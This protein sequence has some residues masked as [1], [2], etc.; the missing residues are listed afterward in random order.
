ALKSGGAFLPIDPE[1]PED[2]IRFILEDSGAKILVTGRDTLEKRK[3]MFDGIK[4]SGVELMCVEDAVKDGKRDDLNAEVPYDALAYVI[5]TSGSTGKPKGVMLTNKNL[6]NFVDDDEKNHEIQG[7]TKRGHVSLAIAA[8][9]FDFSIMEEF[10][11][12]ANGMTVVLA[13]H[14][15]IMNP[16]MLAKLMTDNKVDVMSCTPSYLTNLLDMGEFTDAFTNAVK[17]LKSVDLGAEAFPPALFDKLKAINPDICIMN[18]YGPTEATI[19]CTMQVIEDTENI[20]IGIPN[21]NVHVATVDRDGRLQ[22]LGALGELVIMGDGVGRGYIGRDDLNK[23]NFISL[24]DMPAYRSGDLV[25]IRDNGDIEYH[26]RIDNQVKLRGL[27][28]ELGEIESVIN[29]YPGI[30]SSIVIVVK[31]E[32]EYLAAY[33]T[34]D[35]KV[36]IDRLKEHLSSQLTEYMVPQTF[37]QLEEMPLTANGKIDK[38]AL[39]ETGVEE[40]EAVPAEN[41]KQETI[42]GIVKE[43]IG[44]VKIGITTDLFAVGL[45]SLGCIRLC[46]LLAEK[47]GR[48]IT[49]SE[50][51]ENKTIRDIEK[52]LGDEQ[53]EEKYELRDEYPLSMNQM[54]IFIESIRYPDST[55]YNIPFLYEL[56][57]ETDMGRLR[58][59]VEKTLKAHP[60]LSM[61][62]K[63]DD[64]G[65]VKALRSDDIK[66][67]IE[68]DTVLPSNDKLIRPFDL[69]SGEPLCRIGLYDTESGKYFFIDTHHIV[70]DGESIGI[71]FE[72]INAAYLG[73]ELTAE[74]YTGFEA[75][76]DE[77]KARSSERFTKAKDWYDQIFSDR[78][79]VTLPAKEDIKNNTGIGNSVM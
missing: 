13:T 71:L 39:P 50:L 72:D 32:T 68:E 45:S 9:T 69:M 67:R 10:I 55:V 15:E 35:D 75:A 33:F 77:E 57:K 5:Y 25:R 36:E 48:S 76:L 58:E 61:I 78:G 34:A 26:G 23:K 1:Y 19:S 44:D 41:E 73:S 7:Y 52:L 22:P 4:A 3:E 31:K 53:D 65:D 28:V 47:F 59:A 30:R 29:S 8:L 56:D 24:L 12:I 79:N 21:V 17:A 27:R 18:G 70:S 60:Y 66:V 2:R 51:F 49:I 11:P 37:M 62:L 63:R 6:V 20:T 40:V 54:G 43:V 42:L 46:A 16:V 38:K 14:D 74:S 64:E